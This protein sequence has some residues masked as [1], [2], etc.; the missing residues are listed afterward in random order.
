MSTSFSALPSYL[1]REL[2]EKGVRQSF[3]AS[4]ELIRE[5]QFVKVVP[6]VLSGLIKVYG[7]FDDKELLLYYIQ[8]E[9]TCIMSFTAVIENSPSQVYA[10]TEEATDTILISTALVREWTQKYPA[11][12]LLYFQQYHHRYNELIQTISHLVFEKTEQ[13]LLHYLREQAQVKNTSRLNLRHREI[14]RDLGT[15][16]E[17]ISRL[18][19]KLEKMEQVKQIEHGWIEVL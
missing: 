11:F 17:V 12:N 8:A 2:L 18:M 7:Q 3:P 16:R 1:R 6:F 15:A 4:T 10:I 13:R 5:G 19:K 9:E 14:A